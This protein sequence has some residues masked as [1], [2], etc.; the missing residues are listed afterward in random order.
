MYCVLQKSL[1]LNMIDF[2]WPVK[3][4]DPYSTLFQDFMFMGDEEISCTLFGMW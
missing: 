1:Y 2:D 3:I 4:M